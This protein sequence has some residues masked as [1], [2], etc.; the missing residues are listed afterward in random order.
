MS[1][2]CCP[3][4]GAHTGASLCRNH[5]FQF[6]EVKRFGPKY[7]QMQFVHTALKQIDSVEKNIVLRSESGSQLPLFDHF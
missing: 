4:A 5:Y 3:Q 1:S 6:V 2:R 7:G